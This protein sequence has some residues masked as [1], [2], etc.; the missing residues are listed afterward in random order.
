MLP[1]D[2]AGKVRELQAVRLRVGRGRAQRFEQLMD[3]LRQQL[4]KQLFE[5]MSGAMQNDDAARTWPA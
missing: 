2:L 1:D 5:Q 3:Q 4:A